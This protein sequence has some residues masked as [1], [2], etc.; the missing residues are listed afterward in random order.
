VLIDDASIDLLA[1]RQAI[2]VIVWNEVEEKQ[3]QIKYLF[4]QLLG[5]I[6]RSELATKYLHDSI[7]S[8]LCEFFVYSIFDFLFVDPIHEVL[9][10]CSSI[11]VEDFHPIFE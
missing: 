6:D 3:V 10:R 8:T 7:C 5:I 9:A 1:L 2:L 4:N 11:V